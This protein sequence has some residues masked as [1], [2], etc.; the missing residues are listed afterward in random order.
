[1]KVPRQAQAALI[2]CSSRILWGASSPGATAQR[3]RERDKPDV[4][5]SQ[6][7]DSEVGDQFCGIIAHAS[8]APNISV[9]DH[10]GRI[11][12]SGVFDSVWARF[13]PNWGGRAIGSMLI[14]RL[15][16]NFK[17]CDCFSR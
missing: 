1:M 4:W 15:R 6:T 12:N 7:A 9:R 14:G 2:H 16:P 8:I 3:A 11:S 10:L 13:N 5:S 17:H